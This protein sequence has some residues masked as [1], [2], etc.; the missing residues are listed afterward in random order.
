VI[1]PHKMTHNEHSVIIHFRGPKHL[2][3]NNK[4]YSNMRPVHNDKCFMKLR[5][6]V[7]KC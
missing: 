4:I 3:Q 1:I 2:M 7:R 5:I 6:H